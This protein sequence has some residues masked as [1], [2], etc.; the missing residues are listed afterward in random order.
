MRFVRKK[1][2]SVALAVG[3]VCSGNAL[4]FPTIDYPE[5]PPSVL[6]NIRK[7]KQHGELIATYTTWIDQNVNTYLMRIES[8]LGISFMKNNK[9]LKLNESLHNL[10]VQEQSQPLT[11]VCGIIAKRPTATS[12]TGNAQK[13]ANE[14]DNYAYNSVA[15]YSLNTKDRSAS[16]RKVKIISS[17]SERNINT[18]A[19][20]VAEFNS[21][22]V[23]NYKELKPGFSDI[24]LSDSERIEALQAQI[25]APM[26]TQG[27]YMMNP[28]AFL[29]YSQKEEEAMKDFVNLVIPPYVNPNAYAKAGDDDE[30]IKDLSQQVK[31]SALHSVLSNNVAER[32]PNDEGVSKLALLNETDKYYWKGEDSSG[33]VE[34]TF[35]TRLN[36]EVL[37]MT[38]TPIMREQALMMATRI[39]YAIDEYKQNL[40]KEYMLANEII[41]KTN[42]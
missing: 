10:K 40:E 6:E 7:V 26:S 32:I 35:V 12:N 33:G 22:I 29:N 30:L 31:R 27:D 19:G 3:L 13:T 23:N 28:N 14:A 2:A 34:D 21:K 20:R 8:T 42:G 17:D 39:Q 5:I 25:E 38:S 37:T 36:T 4:A 15:S 24:E 41:E 9:T 18:Q 1:V 16:D 11:N